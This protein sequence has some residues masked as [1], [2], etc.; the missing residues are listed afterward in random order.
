MKIFYARYSKVF[1]WVCYVVFN[2]NRD[3]RV[4]PFQLAFLPG[5]CYFHI[6]PRSSLVKKMIPPVSFLCWAAV[7]VA[8]AD[9]PPEFT[10]TPVRMVCSA[11]LPAGLP[12]SI[13]NAAL[14]STLFMPLVADT[15]KSRYEISF[16][17]TGTGLVAILPDTL[18]V[19]SVKNPDGANIARDYRGLSTCTAGPHTTVS[20]DNRH[21]VFSIHIATDEPA[22]QTPLE[23]KGSIRVKT[24]EKTETLAHTAQL[25][26]TGEPVELGPF[27]IAVS[28]HRQNLRVKITGPGE[29]FAGLEAESGGETL[30]A[31]TSNIQF[32]GATLSNISITMS[33]TAT[34]TDG[35]TT[36][37]AFDNNAM[38]DMAQ[39]SFTFSSNQ[40]GE[41]RT[42]SFPLPK[43][44]AEANLS[45]SY[46]T[47]LKE[48]DLPFEANVF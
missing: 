2:K 29:L 28:V 30:S 22:P 14:G 41:S 7:G 19:D 46:W 10:V 37:V 12:L 5:F 9:E 4:F 43:D 36:R 45:L 8:W 34:N 11:P 32:A 44:A 48:Q 23:I 33:T 39:N 13:K 21:G 42:Y 24:A 25:D 38:R 27:K 40:D 35:E 6:Q 3:K 18:R 16:L 26:D 31:S 20:D 17:A 15:E 1:A 47:E